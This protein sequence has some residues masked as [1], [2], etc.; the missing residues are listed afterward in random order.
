MSFLTGTNCELIYTNTARFTEKTTWTTEVQINDTAGGG[1]Q[2]HLPPDFWLPNQGSVGRGIR[3]CAK[4]YVSTTA[5]PTFTFTIRAG[6]AGSTAA[7]ILLGSQALTAGS[8]IATIPWYLEGDVFLRTITAAGNTSTV[9]GEGMIWS[10]GFTT[11]GGMNRLAA[12]GAA[13]GADGVATTLA[14][15]ITN[16]INFNAACNT[17]SASNK[18][19]IEQLSV[20]GLN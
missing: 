19:R 8:G 12:G 2:A 13:N 11:Q 9:Q 14:T 6:A 7:A 10:N 4:G 3:I 16:Y 1:V 20:F 17:S 5:T 15:D 18:L